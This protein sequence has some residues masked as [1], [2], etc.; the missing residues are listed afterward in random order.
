MEQ[1]SSMI[2]NLNRK[3]KEAQMDVTNL[4]STQQLHYSCEVT[5]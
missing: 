5:G 3:T 4:F 1:H 2:V